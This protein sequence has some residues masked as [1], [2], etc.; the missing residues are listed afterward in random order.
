[1]LTLDLGLLPKKEHQNL[2]KFCLYC[3]DKDKHRLLY[4]LVAFRVAGFREAGKG[5]HLC[6]ENEHFFLTIRSLG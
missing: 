3:I 5:R 6:M 1:M 2:E 4:M